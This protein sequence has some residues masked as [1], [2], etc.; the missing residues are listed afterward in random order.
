MPDI[1]KILLVL[2]IAVFGVLMITSRNPTQLSEEQQMKFAKI[3]RILIPLVLL[4]AAIKYFV[5]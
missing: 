2:A 3:F 1:I 4:A 5:G